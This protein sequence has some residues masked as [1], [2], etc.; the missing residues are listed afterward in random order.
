MALHATS[1]TLAFAI[2]SACA[3]VITTATRTRTADQN[4][5]AWWL[6]KLHWRT[7]AAHGQGD[8][9]GPVKLGGTWHMFVDC[10][11]VWCHAT[12]SDGAVTWQDHGLARPGFGVGIGTGSWS[13]LPNGTKLGL[14]CGGKGCGPDLECMGVLTSDDDNLTIIHDHGVRLHMPANLSGFRD[15]ARAFLSADGTRMCAVLGAGAHDCDVGGAK[16]VMYCTNDLANL[17]DWHYVSTIISSFTR[18]I[19]PSGGEVR[20]LDDGCSGL[21]SCPDFFPLSI[22]KGWWMFMGNYNTY[23]SSW[24]PPSKY[25]IGSFDGTSYVP[26]TGGT[27]GGDYDYV[28]KSGA[29]EANTG[30]RLYWSNIGASIGGH[31]GF[32]SLSHELALAPTHPAAPKPG[33]EPPR[34]A[35]TPPAGPGR[36][37]SQAP[38][39]APALSMTFVPELHALRVGGSHAS[40]RIRK[41]SCSRTRPQNPGPVRMPA[42]AP[43]RAPTPAHAGGGGS[44]GNLLRA[45]DAYLLGGFRGHAQAEVRARFGPLP[46]YSGSDA[47]GMTVLSSLAAGGTTLQE[48]TRIG[49]D[50]YFRT[51]FVDRSNSNSNTSGTPAKSAKAVDQAILSYPLALTADG[52]LELVV[53]IDGAIVEVC[54][55]NQTCFAA[56]ATT[57]NATSTMVGVFGTG[58][59]ADVQLDAWALKPLYA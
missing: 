15:P 44:S 32:L 41:A 29:A 3:C 4:G 22:S 39:P 48:T 8:P 26:L 20:H 1:P 12:S 30:R 46:S 36:G 56:V 58:T 55:N 33:P 53:Y 42:A 9:T 27:L 6:P 52:V 31:S 45:G 17:H 50:P 54:A 28:P 40:A 14:Y 2:A 10:D 57:S 35:A 59:T 16:A 11:S 18:S 25:T 38:L 47:Y 49:Y 5:A 7:A 51:V 37:A 24:Y 23:R 19:S 21:I 43:L 13:V 34:P